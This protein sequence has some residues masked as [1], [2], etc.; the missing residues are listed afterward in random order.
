VTLGGLS[1]NHQTLVGDD[2]TVELY[3]Q[4]SILFSAVFFAYHLMS[5]YKTFACA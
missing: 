4:Y 3:Y 5:S 1:F 2:N